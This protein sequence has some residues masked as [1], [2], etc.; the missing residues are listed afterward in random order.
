MKISTKALYY[1]NEETLENA[2][3]FCAAAGFDALDLNTTAI[4]EREGN[5]ERALAPRLPS[6]PKAAYA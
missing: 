1:S 4:L 6:R 5:W 3:R 2:V